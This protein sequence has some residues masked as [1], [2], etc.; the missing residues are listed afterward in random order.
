MWQPAAVANG[1]TGELSR[2]VRA[3]MAEALEAVR[4]L[5]HR[6]DFAGWN[7]VAGRN[8]YRLSTASLKHLAEEAGMR[9]GAKRITPRMERG[10]SAFHGGFL[11]GLFDADGSV[12]RHAGARAS[13]FALAQ[14]DRRDA[15]RPC[16]A[17]WL[18]LGIA[19]QH[20]PGAVGRPEARASCPTAT[21]ASA[22]TRT[23]AQHE[24]VISGRESCGVSRTSI[25][26]GRRR[27]GT[28]AWRTAC[29]QYRRGAQPRAA[30]RP[31]SIGDWSAQRSRARVRRAGARQ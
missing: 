26:F 3:V 18:R 24:L 17:C 7:M 12:Q 5:P 29:S 31:G 19:A 27:Q 21:A 9:P 25:G 6:A 23:R 20:L 13:A 30:S 16:S 10:S 4:K 2:G 28:R 15:R 22:V 8:E 1:A 11:R 14:S